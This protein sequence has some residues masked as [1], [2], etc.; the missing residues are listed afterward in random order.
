M[1]MT[2]A[3]EKEHLVVEGG[4]AVGVSALLAG[5]L[6]DMGK[7]AVLVISGSNVSLSTLLK[8]AQETYPYQAN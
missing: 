4:G 3:L 5:K 1:G 2:F 6:T 8:S 7:T